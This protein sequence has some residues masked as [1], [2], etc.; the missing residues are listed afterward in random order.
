[1][2]LLWENPFENLWRKKNA[3]NLFVL[4]HLELSTL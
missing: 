4:W 1:M 2:N 3:T